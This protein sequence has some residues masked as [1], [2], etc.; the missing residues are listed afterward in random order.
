[1][2]PEASPPGDRASA[3]RKLANSALADRLLC[4]SATETPK[5]LKRLAFGMLAQPLRTCQ[6][7]TCR[8][9]VTSRPSSQVGAIDLAIP[10]RLEGSALDELNRRDEGVRRLP[11]EQSRH[12]RLSHLPPVHADRR[13][14]W[15]EQL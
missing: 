11:G 1:M 14:R 7:P 13:Q 6:G 12:Q 4:Q 2:P 9:L 5:C 8:P 15:V 10:G 3:G